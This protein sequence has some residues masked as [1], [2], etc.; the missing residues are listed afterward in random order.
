MESRCAE[1]G[2]APMTPSKST[3]QTEMPAKDAYAVRPLRCPEA[4][5]IDENLGAEVNRRLMSWIEQVGIF[6]GKQTAVRDSNFGRF[7]MLCHRDTDDPDR[8][9]LSAQCF[10][11]L[12]AVDDYYCDDERTGSV[13]QLVGPRLS[14]AL[15]AMEPAYLPVPFSVE[16]DQALLRDPVLVALRAYM[17]RVAQ[18]ST[19]SQLARIRHE[20]IAM[21]VTMTA[22]A[23]WRIE[24]MV[25]AIW[26]YL[27]QRQI[28]SFLPCMSLID[29]IGGYEL[30]ANIYSSPAVRRVTVLAASATMIANDLY[31]ARKENMAQIGDFNLPSLLAR[32]QRGSLSDAMSRSADIHDE[33]VRLYEEADQ[34][35]R[36]GSSSLLLRYLNGVQTWLAGNLEWHKHSGRYQV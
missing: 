34:A 22:E 12:F 23:T 9:L 28:N 1:A 7:A 18:F 30:P 14:L 19:P 33:V 24:R 11:A 29:V 15:A 35:L 5:D 10:A 25:P 20:T 16:L 4:Q 21:F 13:P 6:P 3:A 2:G 32:E 36:A 27:A 8:L 26:E 31:S 17:H